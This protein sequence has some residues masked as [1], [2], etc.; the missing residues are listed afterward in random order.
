M[1]FKTGVRF[2]S[3]IIFLQN[4]NSSTWKNTWETR[5]FRYFPSIILC[6]SRRHVNRTNFQGAFDVASNDFY[7]TNVVVHFS[8]RFS[9]CKVQKSLGFFPLPMHITCPRCHGRS[10]STSLFARDRYK[11]RVLFFVTYVEDFSY[12][13]KTVQTNRVL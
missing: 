9:F 5:F 12:H 10:I 7:R 4:S 11:P 2:S 6:S 13:G 1:W 3:M 8:N